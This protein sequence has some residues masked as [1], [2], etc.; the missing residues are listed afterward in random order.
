M[1]GRPGRTRRDE[2]SLPKED[3]GTIL[4][5]REYR[6]DAYY[7]VAVASQPEAC[8]SLETLKRSLHSPRFP[9]YLGRKSCP[10]ALPLQP[11]VVTAGNVRDAFAA[12]RFADPDA[13]LEQVVGRRSQGRLDTGESSLYW[14]DGMAAGM[15]ARETFTRRDQPRTRRRWQ[16]DVRQENHARFGGKE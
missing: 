10:P 14:D 13:L 6:C 12:A 8:C 9:L 3:Q 2:L 11:Q 4:S 15:E 7:Q 16:F 1:K 5:S